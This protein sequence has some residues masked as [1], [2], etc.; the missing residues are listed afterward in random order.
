[1]TLRVLP[2][3]LVLAFAACSRADS[4]PQ[5]GAGADSVPSAEAIAQQRRL[6]S[7][8]R[9]PGYVIDTFVPLPEALRQ[10]REATPGVAP[11]RIAGGA[12]SLDELLG[13][14]V[15]AYAAGDTAGLRA[16]SVDRAEYAWLYYPD[17]PYPRPGYE[18]SAEFVWYLMETH[19]AKGAER[20]SQRLGGKRWTVLGADCGESP[21]V[22]G[23]NRVWGPCSLRLREGSGP[24]S[25][26][27][28]AKAVLERD[29]RFKLLGLENGI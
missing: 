13:R 5:P 10:F 19:G 26:L 25:T 4:A 17:S 22:E 23:A 14:L 6:D 9:I 20:A 11:E 2:L 18:L 3:I 7:L 1:M 16:L 15:D 21:S 29:G 12:A 27:E 8:R 24:E 28:L